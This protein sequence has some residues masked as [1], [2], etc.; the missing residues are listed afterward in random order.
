[1]I[2]PLRGLKTNR[3]MDRYRRI[4]YTQVVMTLKHELSFLKDGYYK[5]LNTRDEKQLGFYRERMRQFKSAITV[6]DIQ[7]RRQYK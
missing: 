6:L 2:K 7:Q 5:A 4:D 3:N 1:M